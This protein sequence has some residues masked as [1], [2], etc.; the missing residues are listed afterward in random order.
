MC[1]C[2]YV[3]VSTYVYIHTYIHM[4]VNGILLR[5]KKEWDLAPWNNMDGYRRWI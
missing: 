3:C 4:Y 2:V 5:H 1:V